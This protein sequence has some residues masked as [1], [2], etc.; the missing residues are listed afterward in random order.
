MRTQTTFLIAVCAMWVASPPLTADERLDRMA[1]AQ[2][3]L[4]AWFECT[5]CTDSE[6]ENLLKYQD[7]IEGAL[8]T[9]LKSGPS[10]SQRALIE[11]R[12]RANYRTL[13]P[14]VAVPGASPMTVERYVAFF[15]AQAKKT[16]QSRAATALGRLSTDSSANELWS[17]VRAGAESREVVEAARAALRARGLLP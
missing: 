5:E 15:S 8:I 13:K 14:S 11:E 6:L 12:L 9:T 3:A 10:P 1:A 2:S 4:V 16:Y 17:V 7:L